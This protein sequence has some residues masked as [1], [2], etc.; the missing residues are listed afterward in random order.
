MKMTTLSEK[1]LAALPCL[2]QGNNYRVHLQTQS[3]FGSPVIIKSLRPDAGGKS[4]PRLTNEHHHTASLDLQGIR[5]SRENFLID[6]YPA[7]ALDYIEG[8][9]HKRPMSNNDN[10]CQKILQ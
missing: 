6:G 9:T 1:D 2:H 10:P 8:E 4:A 3:Q 7:L 5:A